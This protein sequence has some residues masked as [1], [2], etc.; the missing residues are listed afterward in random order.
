MADF[1]PAFQYTIRREGGF[2]NHTVVGDRGGQTYAGIARNANPGWPGWLL[3][4]ANDVDNPK[5]TGLVRD[6]YRENFWKRIKGDEIADQDVATSLFDFAV[7]T[8]VKKAVTIAQLAA[9]ITADGIVG[10]KS[11]KAINALDPEIF[12]LRLTIGKIS[13]YAAIC[14]A[15]RTQTK[16]LLGWINRSVQGGT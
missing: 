9:Q 10:E 16:F 1:E 5:L 11:I 4:D 3:L 15:D 2:V 13:R 14:N 8:G 7:N 6:F 12:L